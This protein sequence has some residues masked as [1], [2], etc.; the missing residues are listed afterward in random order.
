MTRKAVFTVTLNKPSN[1]IVTVEY[2]TEDGTAT[3]PSDYTKKTGT[4]QFLPGETSKQIEISIRDALPIAFKEE[5]KV[6]LNSPFHATI[7]VDTAIATIPAGSEAAINGP[8]IKNGLI[9]NAYHNE[10]GRGGYFHHNSGTSE[11]QSIGIEGSFLA[12]QVLNG[13]TAAE[14]AAADW[15]LKNGENML[16]AMGSGDTKGPMLR[17]PITSDVDNLTLL[18]WLFAARGEIQLQAIEYSYLATPVGGTLTVPASNRDEANTMYR[19]FR[20]YPSTS[21]LIYNSPYSAAVDEQTVVSG[22][23]ATIRSW[24]DS[25]IALLESDY[26]IDDDGNCVITIPTDRSRFSDD[27]PSDYPGDVTSWFVVYGFSNAGTLNQGEAQEAYPMW[28]RIADGYAA[29]APDTFRW[30][31]NAMTIA[32]ATDPRA[33]KVVLWQRLRDAMR[34]TAVRGQRISDGRMVIEPMPQFP[35][36]PTSGDPTGMFCYSDD[37]SAK[38]PPAAAIAQGANPA[39]KGYSWFSRTAGEGG[40]VTKDEFMWTP[41]R[42]LDE[43]LRQNWPDVRNSFLNGAL[44]YK[45]PFTAFK[46]GNVDGQTVTSGKTQPFQIGRGIGEEYREATDYQDPDQFMFV[47]IRRK[48][49]EDTVP[50]P[51]ISTSQSYSNDTRYRTF[52]ILNDDG[53]TPIQNDIDVF[54][55][56]RDR[57]TKDRNY[58]YYYLFK[59]SD[60]KQVGNATTSLIPGSKIYNMGIICYPGASLKGS[61]ADAGNVE[62][63]IIAMRLVS[64]PTK[65]WV[66]NN[67]VKAVK[68]STMPWFPGAMPFAI[69]ADTIKQRIVG[70]SGSPFHG[71][72]LPDYWWVLAGD[73]AAVH[74]TIN[75]ATDLPCCSTSGAITYPISPLT[76]GSV[77]KPAHAMLA[78]QQLL[79]LKAAAD[80]WVTDG[81]AVGGFAHTFVM[82]TDARN[83]LGSPAPTPHTWVYTNDDPNTRW[84]GYAARV[85]ESLARLV[86]LSKSDTGWSTANA[87]ALDMAYKWVNML[88]TLWPN[89]NGK[90]YNDPDMGNII[91]YGSPTDYPDPRISAPQTLYEEPHATALILRAVLWLNLSGKLTAGQKAVVDAVGK[92]CWDYMEMRYRNTAGD[93]MRY[94]WA[95][96]TA[97]TAEQYYGFWEFEIITTICQM[98]QNPTGVPAGINLTTARQ[99]L[100]ETQSW[101]AAHTE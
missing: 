88:N 83:S 13:G 81:G 8:L 69:N 3:Q 20:I 42:M 62:S 36:L 61:G 33:D 54:K 78:E 94:T 31:D 12:Y 86:L 22:Q 91:I 70:W 74:G 43:N 60:F 15:Y 4:V 98:I 56:Q 41:E 92:R 11:G 37:K 64:G 89:L 101:V 47:A 32:M 68:G 51:F 90:A 49:E 30:F 59:L 50:I 52:F 71:Y 18:H 21:K 58:V 6:T 100:T 19:A 57:K 44:H 40:V 73:A 2:T 16:D 63:D 75:P 46:Y 27:A 82:N 1:K 29:C 95:N 14:Q 66:M 55:L 76:A 96:V 25:S 45:V 28:T 93:T 80:K 23:T 9:T 10:E 35:A 39:W 65:A 85:V 84:C 26:V 34:R 97:K 48:G 5:F 17:Q 24:S 7:K 67:I 72:Q 38:S 77:A 87:L 99:R 79:F 53:T